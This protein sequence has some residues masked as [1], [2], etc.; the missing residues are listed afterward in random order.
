MQE[1]ITIAEEFQKKNLLNFNLDK[2]EQ[3]V[4]HYSKSKKVQ[5]DPLI[6]NDKVIKEGESYKYLGDLKNNKGT[7]DLCL[8]K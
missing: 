3:M 2:S 6:L 4:M 8:S 5:N 7:L 1:M